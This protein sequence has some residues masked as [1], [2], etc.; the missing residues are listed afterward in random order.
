MFILEHS[1]DRGSSKAFLFGGWQ[2]NYSADVNEKDLIRWIIYVWVRMTQFN[3]LWDQRC[4][5]N[6]KSAHIDFNYYSCILISEFKFTGQ[7][8]LFP[9]NT[10]KL[11]THKTL[12]VVGKNRKETTYKNRVF[13]SLFRELHKETLASHKTVKSPLPSQILAICCGW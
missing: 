12:Y 10:C 9:L 2:M 13:F 11:P 7:T 8:L 5:L 4:S 1:K 3:D 6:F